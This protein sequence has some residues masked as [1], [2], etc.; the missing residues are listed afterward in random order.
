MPMNEP[1]GAA[2]RISW[3]EPCVEPELSPRRMVS[4]IA[5]FDGRHFQASDPHG[6]AYLSFKPSDRILESP[7]ASKKMSA[8]RAKA[9]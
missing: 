8:F 2:V 4:A 3:V 5:G 1:E 9:S 6:A 7:Q